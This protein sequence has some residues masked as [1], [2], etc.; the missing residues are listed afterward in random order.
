MRRMI[1]VFVAALA[2]VVAALAVAFVLFRAPSAEKGGV[3][4]EANEAGAK[5][6]LSIRVRP[7][8]A[9]SGRLFDFAPDPAHVPDK[10]ELYGYHDLP[11]GG[12]GREPVDSI[13]VDVVLRGA[14]ASRL[15]DAGFKLTVFV[16]SGKAN[17]DGKGGDRQLIVE[18]ILEDVDF[19]PGGTHHEAVFVIGHTCQELAIEAEIAKPSFFSTKTTLPFTCS[20]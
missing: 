12:H 20:P 6:P 8:G 17:P 3:A 2:L 15:V 5:L 11:K 16:V 9:Y 10:A 7:F 4:T 19:G 14:A 1:I 18:R 13:L